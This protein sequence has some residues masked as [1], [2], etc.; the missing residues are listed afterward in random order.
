MSNS[1]E[2]GNDWKLEQM[3]QNQDA[4]VGEGHIIQRCNHYAEVCS[5]QSESS[6]FRP[7]K[8]SLGGVL[9]W[10]SRKPTGKSGHPQQK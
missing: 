1:K 10:W 9:Q 3:K 8:I 4:N 6:V 7:R 5:L 2:Q